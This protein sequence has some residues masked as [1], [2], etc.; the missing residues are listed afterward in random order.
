MREYSTRLMVL[1]VLA[2][3]QVLAS[4]P[5][6]AQE[7][8]GRRGGGFNRGGGR[9]GLLG[10]LSREEAQ[11]EINF[12]AE[13]SEQFEALQEKV[14]EQSRELFAGMRDAAPEERQEL[15][16]KARAE[17]QKLQETAEADLKTILTADQAARLQQVSWQIQ[18]ARALDDEEVNSQL[19][20]TAE[21]LKQISAIVEEANESRRG[22]FGGRRRYWRRP[23]QS[24]RTARGVGRK[25]GGRLDARTA[26]TMDRDARPDGRRLERTPQSAVATPG[27][28]DPIGTNPRRSRTSRNELRPK[29]R[30]LRI[31]PPQTGRS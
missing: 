3:F 12:T 1:L 14:R 19:K 22:S 6:E 27:E 18:G 5:V 16:E 30:F 8:G 25:I 7:R 13:Q 11:T 10:A 28:T 29:P 26:T 9:S 17:G 2:M 15:M 4:Q 20:L 21:Q 31:L 24:R 23:S